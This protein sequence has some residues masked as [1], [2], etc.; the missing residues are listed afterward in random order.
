M[1][2]NIIKYSNIDISLV[3]AIKAWG[4]DTLNW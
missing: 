1:Y 4:H 3:A 2:M